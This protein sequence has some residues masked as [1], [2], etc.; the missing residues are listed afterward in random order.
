MV[1]QYVEGKLVQIGRGSGGCEGH[2]GVYLYE[3]FME[4]CSVLV[5][6]G[7]VFGFLTAGDHGH[8][9]EARSYAPFLRELAVCL[10]LMHIWCMRK[11]VC[12]Q[13]PKN[14]RWVSGGQYWKTMHSV[15]PLLRLQ[16]SNVYI[17]GERV[18]PEDVLIL[19]EDG[20][21]SQ[22]LRRSRKILSMA[23]ERVWAQSE[24]LK[25][26]CE[27]H[28]VQSYLMS[29]RVKAEGGKFGDRTLLGL[30]LV[31]VSPVEELLEGSPEEDVSSEWKHY[32]TFGGYAPFERI[33]ESVV[34]HVQ[35]AGYKVSVA[36]RFRF[37]A[38]IFSGRGF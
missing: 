29:S 12:N 14:R 36:W 13:T 34:G 22:F 21:R 15:A 32:W 26:I 4:V 24:P 2:D 18:M 33:Y 28:S 1:T 20:L 7:D 25:A 27:V 9:D 6:V 37:L 23:R 38:K 10:E 17:C 31:A 5:Y 11:P 8:V 19:R 16:M 30:R 35:S 3:V